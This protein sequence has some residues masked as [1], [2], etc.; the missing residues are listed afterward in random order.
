MEVG[1]GQELGLPCLDPALLGEGLALRAVP[2]AA[3]V[4]DGT[5]APTVVT[6]L[7][8]PTEG[9][10]ATGIDGA[11]GA[12]LNGGQD[13]RRTNVVAVKADDVRELGSGPPAGCSPV[14]K[15][16]GHGSAALGLR[17]IEQVQ[18]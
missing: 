6:G 17:E 18:R 2:V 4:V 12:E 11:Q 13:L 10:C 9:G 8:V 7:P 5:A 15:R 1:H 14:R 3:R 16:T